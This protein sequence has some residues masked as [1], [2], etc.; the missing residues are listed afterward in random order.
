MS[1]IKKRGSNQVGHHLSLYSD[2]CTSTSQ[3]S[4]RKGFSHDDVRSSYRCSRLLDVDDSNAVPLVCSKWLYS[5]ALEVNDDIVCTDTIVVYESVLDSLC[6]TLRES[7][8]DVGIT[9]LLISIADDV[10]LATIC[11]SRLSR[12]VYVDHLVLVDL[13]TA[14]TEGYNILD[15]RLGSRSSLWALRARNRTLA[16]LSILST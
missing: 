2:A 8:V 6:T 11:L 12:V 9:S 14:D 16:E 15:N 1:V 5:V 4:S 3:A 10:D 7:H 13:S